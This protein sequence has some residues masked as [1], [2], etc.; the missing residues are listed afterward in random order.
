MYIILMKKGVLAVIS[1]KELVRITN[2][3][4]KDIVA[5]YSD[6]P[7]SLESDIQEQEERIR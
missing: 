3:V 6:P 5:V 1:S 7:L 4:K 2:E